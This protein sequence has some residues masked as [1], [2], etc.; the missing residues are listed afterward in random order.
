MIVCKGTQNAYYPRPD[1]GSGLI[2]GTRRI[3]YC[4]GFLLV[5]SKAALPESG[6]GKRRGK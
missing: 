4:R 5:S 2:C 3:R 6:S 1:K